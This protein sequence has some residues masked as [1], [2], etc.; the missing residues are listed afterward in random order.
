MSLKM[1]MNGRCRINATRDKQEISARRRCP[2]AMFF[3]AIG[4]NIA[5]I[6]S[7]HLL[8]IP[9]TAVL[10]VIGLVMGVGA[11]HSDLEDRLIL[12]ILDWTH[13]NSSVLFAVF[14]PGLYFKWPTIFCRTDGVLTLRS[15][16]VPSSRHRIQLLYQLFSMK[17]DLHR[18]SKC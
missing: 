17:S 18:D 7:R 14:L 6:L 8:G 13:V 12:S 2:F 10:F 1:S 16:S 9:Y 5:N 15:H 11:V 3:Q 4:V